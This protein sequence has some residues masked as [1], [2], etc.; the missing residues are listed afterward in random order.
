[1]L[2]RKCPILHTFFSPFLMGFFPHPFLAKNPMKNKTV[3]IYA[4][5]ST[6]QQKADLQIRELRSFVKRSGWKL[7]REYT[8]AGYSGKDTRRPEYARMMEDARRR[9]FHVLLVWKLDRLSRSTKDLLNTVEGT[10]RRKRW[11]AAGSGSERRQRLHVFSARS[12]TATHDHSS[13]CPAI[14]RHAVSR[15]SSLVWTMSQMIGMLTPK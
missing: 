3:A 12:R 1:M 4:R 6:G 8:D 10:R 5:V 7:V 14:S 15:A 11:A 9:M 2:Y 13:P